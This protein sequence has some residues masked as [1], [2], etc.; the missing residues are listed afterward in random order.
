MSLDIHDAATIALDGGATAAAWQA[1][2]TRLHGV[3]VDATHVLVDIDRI[4]IGCIIAN[5]SCTHNILTLQHTSMFKQLLF[6]KK[7]K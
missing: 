2:S 3:D 1:V 5:I 6:R 4:Y 7:T